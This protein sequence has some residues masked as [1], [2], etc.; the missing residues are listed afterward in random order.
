MLTVEKLKEYGADV[1][2]GLSRCANN[3]MLYL[4]LVKICIDELSSKALSEALQ[5]HDYD[6][7]FQIAHKLKGGVTNLSLDPVSIPV[8]KLTE[9]LRNK[10]PGDYEGLNNEI[11]SETNKLFSLMD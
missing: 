4:R 5:Q 7:A 3:E 1:N 2:T 8:C 10:T 6:K 11:I 9:L